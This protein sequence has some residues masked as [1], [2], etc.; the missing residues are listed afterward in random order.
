MNVAMPEETA[1]KAAA[2]DWLLRLSLETPTVEDRI[3]FT[4]WCAAD[5]R[6]EA[7]YRRYQGIWKDAATLT[8]LAPLA[9]PDEEPA[10]VSVATARAARARAGGRWPLSRWVAGSALA[11]AL[12]VVVFLVTRPPTHYQTGVAQ[13][14]D[15]ELPDGSVVTLG[16]RSALDVQFASAERR[17]TR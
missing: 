10:A 3:R 7:A 6:H 11:A 17:V 8:A 9:L 13:I 14:Q 5:P 16:A 12:A 1:I 4:H 2:R 15:I